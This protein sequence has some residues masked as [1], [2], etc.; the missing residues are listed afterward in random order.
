MET[1]AAS[2]YW[3]K[4]I[5]PLDTMFS[6]MSRWWTS[7]GNKS[8]SWIIFLQVATLENH[9]DVSS[10]TNLCLSNELKEEEAA[11]ALFGVINSTITTKI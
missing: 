3:K 7:L 6:Y 8:L 9:V 5:H 4:I 1:T 10:L 11:R 2:G